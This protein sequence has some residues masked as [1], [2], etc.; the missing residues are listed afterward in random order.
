MLMEMGSLGVR[1]RKSVRSSPLKTKMKEKNRHNHIYLLVCWIDKSLIN[2]YDNFDYSVGQSVRLFLF[3]P[4]SFIHSSICVW[5]FDT[6]W[7]LFNLI[8]LSVSFFASSFIRSFDHQKGDRFGSSREKKTKRKKNNLHHVIKAGV[9]HTF[10]TQWIL[11]CTW[12]MIH[13]F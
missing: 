1:R 4:H 9:V 11:M 12:Y 6:V 2:R 3:L 13:A 8:F 7:N 5:W 10:I